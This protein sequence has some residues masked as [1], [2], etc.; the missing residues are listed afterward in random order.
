MFYNLS[1][2]KK[3]ETPLTWASY[4]GNLEVV[5]F[6]VDRGAEVESYS[7]CLS[8]FHSLNDLGR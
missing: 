5:Q 8:A 6:L 7:V 4:Y 2:V 3:G 1:S